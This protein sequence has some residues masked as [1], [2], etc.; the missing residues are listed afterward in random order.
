[1]LQPLAGF[2]AFLPFQEPAFQGMEILGVSGV[3]LAEAMGRGE[4]IY[5]KRPSWGNHGQMRG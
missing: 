4:V 2:L 3:A 1:M 5:Y